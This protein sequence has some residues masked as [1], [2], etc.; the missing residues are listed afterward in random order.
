MAESLHPSA[1][2]HEF[3]IDPGQRLIIERWT[4]DVTLDTLVQG[5]AELEQHPDFDPRF[6]VIADYANAR[7][8]VSSHDLQAFGREVGARG[9]TEVGR[10]VMVA[11]RDL[12]FGIGRQ[13]RVLWR[14]DDAGAFRTEREAQEWLSQGPG[15][16]NTS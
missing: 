2:T 13:A 12:E 5:L 8:S 16:G 14:L 9:W 11:P 7:L 6:D 3:E 15:P 1:M 10:W 4:G